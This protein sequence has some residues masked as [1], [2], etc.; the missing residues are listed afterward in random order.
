MQDGVARSDKDIERATNLPH[1]RASGARVAL[2]EVGLVERLEK[3]AHGHWRW[4]LCPLE[5]RAEAMRAYR[6]HSEDRERS[7]LSAKSVGERAGIVAFLL[8]DEGVNEAVISHMERTRA[9]RRAAA[10][11]ND[12]R[13][14]KEAERRDRKRQLRQAQ[15]GDGDALLEFMVVRD[16]L[17]DLIDALLVMQTQLADDVARDRAGE[18]LR[19]PLAHWGSVVRNVHEVLVLA[20]GLLRGLSAAMG[21]PLSS[22]PLCGERLLSVRAL[23]E[24]YV[25]GEAIE[26]D[27]LVET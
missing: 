15:K 24:G 16:R 11:A 13:S 12:V 4:Q 5:R 8:A 19:I 9:W 27:E 14:E 6:D 23:D 1:S 17:R 7:R 26:E 10:R 25:D 20:Q 18:P 22:C 21:E 2:W 3:D